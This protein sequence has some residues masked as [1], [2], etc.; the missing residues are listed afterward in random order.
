MPPSTSTS[1][2]FF[3]IG[4][5]GS[6]KSLLTQGIAQSADVITIEMD[7]EIV[8]TAGSSINDIFAR[9]GEEGFRKRERSILQ[10][11]IHKYQNTDQIV[12]VSTGGGV[13][14]YSDNMELMNAAGTTI[15]INPSA[16][17]LSHRLEQKKMNRPLIKDLS[18]PELKKY[19][20]NMLQRRWPYYSQATLIINTIYDDKLL[21]IDFLRSIVLA[22]GR[23]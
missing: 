12:L 23:K 13:P 2:I 9:E 20:R 11:I 14:C 15:F 16:D 18:F 3:F 21:N 4:F 19:V 10:K 17:R 22:S 1:N 8:N 7:E 6:G 5:M